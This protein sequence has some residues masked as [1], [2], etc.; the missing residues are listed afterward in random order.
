[1]VLLQLRQRFISQDALERVCALQQVNPAPVLSLEAP[2]RSLKKRPARRPAAR[3]AHDARP[4]GAADGKVDVNM[5]LHL[6]HVAADPRNLVLE[7]DFVAENLARLG[8]CA[9][10]VQ[11]RCDDGRR[12]LLVVEDGD[13]AGGHED[14]EDGEAA[15]PAELDLVDV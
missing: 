6:V 3:E 14:D 8:R 2:F 7:V 10:R 9:Q 12:R 11:C 4:L 15:A 13:R 1:M 5:A